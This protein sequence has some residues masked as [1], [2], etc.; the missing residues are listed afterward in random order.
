MIVKIGI[1]SEGDQVLNCW[2][3]KVAIRRVN[4]DVDIFQITLENNIPAISQDIWRITCG[5]NT[6]KFEAS[7]QASAVTT[8]DPKATSTDRGYRQISPVES[9]DDADFEITIRPKRG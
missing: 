2:D 9:C 7:E 1:L 6:V 8:A 3:D 5:N 4:G